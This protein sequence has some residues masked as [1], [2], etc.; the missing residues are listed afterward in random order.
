MCTTI[1]PVCIY[2]N[3]IHAHHRKGQKRALN[4]LEFELK[5]VVRDNVAAGERI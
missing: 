5:A 4:T 1:V 3:H 2:V